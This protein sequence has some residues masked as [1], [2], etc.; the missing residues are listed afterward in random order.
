KVTARLHVT[1][2]ERRSA[3]SPTVSSSWEPW[4]DRKLLPPE[5]AKG[6][7]RAFVERQLRPLPLPKTRA[8]W[9]ARRDS[10]RR[11]ILSIL[12]IEDLVPPKWDLN[13]QSKGT[14]QRDG[15]RIEKLTFESYPD[16][17]ISAILYIPEG[18]AGRVPGIVSISGHIDVSKAADYVQQR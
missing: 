12:G 6:M 7:M 17:A 14:L 15:Y 9:L 16:M 1:V 11:E 3:P 2:E 8:D 10:L 18:V 13:V 5:E 4:L